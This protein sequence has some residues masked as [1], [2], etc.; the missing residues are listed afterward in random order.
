MHMK[1]NT[2][3]RSATLLVL[4]FA[5]GMAQAGDPVKGRGLYEERCAACHGMN[6]TPQVP[7]IPNFAIGEGL[8]KSDRALLEYTK[9]GGTVMPGFAGS[10]SDAEI[11]DIIAHIRT[12]F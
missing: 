1:F 6:G 7:S 3:R 9:Q 5:C 8:N 10:L 12:F 4:L 11:L 2:I